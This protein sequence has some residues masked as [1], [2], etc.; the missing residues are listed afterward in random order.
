[1]WSLVLAADNLI[2]GMVGLVGCLGS[3]GAYQ[4]DRL[5]SISNGRSDGDSP[6]GC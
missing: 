4:R 2:W 5:D 3:R 1:M 6:C